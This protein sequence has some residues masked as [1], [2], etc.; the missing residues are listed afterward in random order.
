[1]NLD[2]LGRAGVRVRGVRLA[3]EDGLGGITG[4][5]P[6]VVAAAVPPVVLFVR[7]DAN[8]DGQIDIAD[9]ITILDYLFGGGHVPACRDAGD[10]NDDGTV[11]IGDAITVLGHLFGGAG[12]LPEP[13]GACGTDPTDDTM[14]CSSYPPCR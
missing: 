5:D 12:S 3:A 1:M 6:S 10:G 2:A 7:G 13:F 14:D 11:D 8:A 9:A 4:L